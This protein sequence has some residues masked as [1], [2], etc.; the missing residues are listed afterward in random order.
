MKNINSIYAL[1]LIKT[2]IMRLFYFMMPQSSDEIEATLSQVL[3]Q[4]ASATVKSISLSL[5]FVGSKNHDTLAIC[6]QKPH[7]N[8]GLQTSVQVG[9]S[10]RG[11][12]TL[13]NCKNIIVKIEESGTAIA[14]ILLSH[15]NNAL[16]S[17]TIGAN[18]DVSGVAKIVEFTRA[19]FFEI[20]HKNNVMLLFPNAEQIELNGVSSSTINT[21]KQ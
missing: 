11:K 12:G 2:V 1:L 9:F 7:Q 21:I 13:V 20:Q 6:T 14:L 17:F 18:D 19:L 10:M 4:R 3:V 5:L 16:H 8:L 15:Y